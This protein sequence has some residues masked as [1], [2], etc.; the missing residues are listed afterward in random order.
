MNKVIVPRGPCYGGKTTI[1]EELSKQ[2]TDFVHVEP[3]QI[4]EELRKLRLISPEDHLSPFLAGNIRAKNYLSQGKNVILDDA[5]WNLD[6]Y[7]IAVEN[8]DDLARIFVID[9]CYPVEEHIKRFK[10]NPNRSRDENSVRYWH[11]EHKKC[12][13]IP[14]D[15]SI[16]DP[17]KDINQIV[18]EI[19]QKIENLEA[20]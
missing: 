9:I 3:D 7:Q 20:I 15:M 8:L 6:L 18:G 12:V 16:D 11:S 19:I 14:N 13:G 4:Y 1:A 5:F 10:K 17:A 2:R